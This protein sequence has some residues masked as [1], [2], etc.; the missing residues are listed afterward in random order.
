MVCW[1]YSTLCLQDVSESKD[2]EAFSFSKLCYI[3]R[4]NHPFTYTFHLLTQIQA[5]PGYLVP[6]MHETSYRNEEKSC[7][8]QV[9]KNGSGFAKQKWNADTLL[10]F[11]IKT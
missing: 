9:D 2:K 10:V 8:F 11:G 5:P 4:S 6:T 7:F 1:V 3:P